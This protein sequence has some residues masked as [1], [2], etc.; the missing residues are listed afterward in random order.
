VLLPYTTLFRSVA[1]PYVGEYRRCKQDHDDQRPAKNGGASRSHTLPSLWANNAALTL[2]GVNGASRRRTPVASKIALA[3]AAAPGTEADS[4]EPSGGLPL[5]G[6][7][8]TSTSGTSG[9]VR[10]GYAPHSKSATPF[11]SK[12]TA[13]FS[14]RLMA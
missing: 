11:S 6:M 9:K 8:T 13:S 12:E 3:I 4:P 1:P 7:S 2:S 5:A 14:V 10:I